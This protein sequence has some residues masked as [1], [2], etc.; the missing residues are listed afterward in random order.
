MGST[1]RTLNAY[2]RG[3]DAYLA[4]WGR[5]RYR[6]PP[7]L[8]EVIRTLPA[9]ASVLDA[10]CGPGQDTGYLTAR[11]FHA[12]GFDALP[13]FLLWARTHDRTMPLVHGAIQSLP[14]RPRSFSAVWAAASLIHLSKRDVRRALSDLQTIIQPGGRLAATFVHGT[15]S[16][17]ITKGWLPG[18][19]MSRWTKDEL[20]TAV[21]RAG[22]DIDSL[23]VVANRE[24]KGR[25]LNL[26]AHVTDN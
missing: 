13:E 12:V 5:R 8:R 11:G 16:G 4:Q 21:R 6:V 10:G 3:L 17:V 18:R 24:R 9:G 7:L 1:N 19:Y 22:W 15:T 25:W 26:L 23:T 2:R 20:A 14:F